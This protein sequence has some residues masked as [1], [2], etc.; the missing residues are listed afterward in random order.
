MKIGLVIT[1]HD[2]P[3]YLNRTLKSLKESYL[4]NDLEV[5]MVNDASK[6]TTTNKIFNEFSLSNKIIKKINNKNEN[7]FYGLRLGWDYF[8]SHGFDLLANIDSDVIVKPYWL[9]ILLQL[10]KMFPDRVISG[11]NTSHHPISDTFNK[12]HAKSTIGGINCLFDKKVYP[13]ISNVLNN[14]QWD[15]NMCNSMKSMNKDFII[16]KPSVAQH[17]GMTSTLRDHTRRD[18]A[19]DF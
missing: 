8:I 7:M 1:I 14:T 13:I 17:I 16:S 3:E 12:Y 19:E 5:F 10:Y 9:P 6:D 18:I 11:F 4:P 2:R 15:W